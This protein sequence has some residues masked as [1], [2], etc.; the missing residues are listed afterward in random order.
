V[1][2]TGVDYQLHIFAVILVLAIV[3][4]MRFNIMVHP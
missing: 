2:C 3:I 1:W 4:D